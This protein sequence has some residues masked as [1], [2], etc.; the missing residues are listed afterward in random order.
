MNQAKAERNRAELRALLRER[1]PGYARELD[2]AVTELRCGPRCRAVPAP[3]GPGSQ[4][5]RRKTGDRT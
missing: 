5:D 4:Q 2:A 3:S 1:M